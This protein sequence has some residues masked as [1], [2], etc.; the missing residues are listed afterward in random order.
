MGIKIKPPVI[1][2]RAKK[3]VSLHLMAHGIRHTLLLLALLSVTSGV[4]AI[5]RDTWFLMRRVFRYA[6]SID[7]TA[8]AERSTYTYQKYHLHTV[9]RN[10]ILL[11]VPTMY[12]VAHGGARE[13]VGESYDSVQ[14]RGL[15]GLHPTR[16]LERTTI[17]HGRRTMPTLLRYLTPRLYDEALLDGYL[18]S[19]FHRRNRWYYRYR[20]DSVSRDT[21]FLSF[22]PRTH[23]TQL[24][25]GRAKVEIWSGRVIEARISGEYDMIRFLLTADM[26]GEGS[27][28][29][30]WQ[31]RLDSRF[32]FLGNDITMSYAARYGL[33]DSPGTAVTDRGDTTLMARVRPT[34]LTAHEHALFSQAAARD[35]VAVDS[36]GVARRRRRTFAQRMWDNVGEHLLGRIKSNFGSRDQGYLRISPI[37]NPLYLG[38]SGRR[39]L[40]Y[41][42][43]I[44]GSYYLSANSLI[45]ARLK[46]GYS[47]KQHQFY[48]NVPVTWYFNRRRE[49]YVRVE[50]GNGNRITN[51][52][53]ADAVKQQQTD[54]IDWEKMNLYYFRD[55]YA[56]L[57]LNYDLS[58]RFGVEVAL[59]THRRTAIDP[60]GFEAAGRPTRY[61]SSA[62][63]IEVRYRPWG[64]AGPVFSVDYERGIKGLFRS[65]T[66][67]ERYEIDGQ[68]KIS[69]TRLSAVQLRLGTGFYTNRGKDAFFLDYTNFHDNR[70]PGGWN[71]DWANNFELLDANWYNASEYYVR[72]NVT[73]ESPMLILSWVPLAGRFVEKERFY[74]NALVVRHL[75]P[76]VE[77]GYGFTT[78][79]FSIGAFVAQ[80]NGRFDG[81]GCKFGFELFRRW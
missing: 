80:R 42:F 67:Y 1:C 73:Y 10:A 68:Y 46:A 50:T 62:P 11:A 38:Y 13:Y 44:R 61:I 59:V 34:P 56:K 2:L 30:P 5:D 8:G 43:D 75:H 7:T 79:L 53:V 27:A 66:A 51:S 6:A 25:E 21:A 20:M 55:M 60:T 40:T 22:R 76:Y 16:L 37:L 28:L 57:T 81:V 18:L 64:Y 29:L 15:Y 47:F 24:V 70:I 12:A 45:E 4:R 3:R 36:S 33:T 9:R 32:R 63:M 74:V 52:T 69:P 77:Y 49:G 65:N 48:Y 71:D 19:P 58:S 26:G 14:V 54:S 39:G 41:K 72:S 78:R 23:N 17:P 35:T 31:C